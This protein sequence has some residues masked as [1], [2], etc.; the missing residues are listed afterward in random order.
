M[1]VPPAARRSQTTG[2][3]KTLLSPTLRSLKICLCFPQCI[4]VFPS[5]SPA[6]LPRPRLLLLRPR[7]LLLL[8]RPVLLAKLE[9]AQRGGHAGEVRE[10]ARSVSRK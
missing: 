7:L 5:R 9:G 4:G 1:R 8:L 3:R 10:F 2:E 6:V